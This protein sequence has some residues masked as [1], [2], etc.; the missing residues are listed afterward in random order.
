MQSWRL[1]RVPPRVLF[2]LHDPQQVELWV[3]AAGFEKKR[4]ENRTFIWMTE[5]Y[6]RA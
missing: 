3:R 6:V 5:V 2:F 4:Y 1:R